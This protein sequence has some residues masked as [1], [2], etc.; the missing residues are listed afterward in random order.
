MYHVQCVF[1]TLLY[2]TQFTH[3]IVSGHL[4]ILFKCVYENPEGMLPMLFKADLVKTIMPLVN[5]PDQTLR[6]CSKT[7]VS[8]LLAILDDT[9]MPFLNLKA[10]EA[11]RLIELLSIATK[12]S[13]ASEGLLTYSTVQLLTS[14]INLSSLAANQLVILKA[15][16]MKPLKSL[17]LSEDYTT[18][19]QSLHLF[20]ILLS[21]RQFSCEVLTGH[22][23]LGDV[24]LMLQFIQ[25]SPSLNLSL[26]AQCALKTIYWDAPEGV[27]DVLILYV[28]RSMLHA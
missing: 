23:E 8:L 13:R 12:E 25:Q 20:W 19:E 4:A 28:M 11:S 6:I 22:L 3:H 18:Q 1:C 26:I 27:S 9:V 15:G 16:I 10:D 14:L 24:R 7:V 17:I 5:S 21:G 2:Y